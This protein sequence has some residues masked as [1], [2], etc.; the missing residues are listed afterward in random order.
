MIIW[1]ASYPKSGNTWVRA[2]ISSLLFDSN[3]ENSLENLKKIRGYPLTSDFHNLLDSFDN[4]KNIAENWKTSQDF[5]NLEKETKIIKTHHAFCQI[6]NYT[7]TNYINSLGAIYIVRDPRNIITSFIN[8]YSSVNNYNDAL[9]FILDK[10]RFLGKFGKKE[11]FKNII[12][13][14]TFISNWGGHY[15]SWKYFKK[16]YL[17][18]KYE[19]LINEPEKVF[20]KIA[21]YLSELLDIKIDK[22]RVDNAIL[23]SS[24]TN[25][26]KNE[27]KFGFHESTQKTITQKRRFFNLG[28][29]NNWQKLLPKEIQNEIEKNF[30]EEMIELGY[31]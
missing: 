16:N 29:E 13:F 25:L 17:L 1:L 10:N 6:D 23:K 3:K 9:K 11:D 12:E 5:I 24:F 26:R 14:P 19:E 15:N 30:K 27:E 31:L 28:P 2:F 18:V 8:H 4:F 21:K 22:E 7:F 20:L